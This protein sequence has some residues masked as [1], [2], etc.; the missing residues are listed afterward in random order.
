MRIAAVES[1]V[2]ALPFSMG[3]PKPP[4][5]GRPWDR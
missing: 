3:G 5:A 4:F 1:S 2:V